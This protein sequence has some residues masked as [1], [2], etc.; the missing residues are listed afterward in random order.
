MA[1]RPKGNVDNAA[2]K[3]ADRPIKGTA[4]GS[5]RKASSKTFDGKVSGRASGMVTSTGTPAVTPSA[6]AAGSGSP[7][8]S[9]PPVSPT[10]DTAARRE[11]QRYLQLTGFPVDMTDFFL[12]KIAKGELPEDAGAEDYT[13]IAVE[14]P[15]FQA[16]FPVIVEQMKR[17]KAGDA[18][19]Q[20]MMPGAV[21]E[22]E[23]ALAEVADD[24]GLSSWVS[25]PEQIS[26]LIL[27]N[28]SASE[29]TERINLAAYA[30]QSAPEQ[31]RKAFIEHQG[32]TEGNLVGYF[33][34]PD[35]EEGEIR[36]QVTLGNIM[37]AA[38]SNG[39]G[40]NWSLAE[41]VYSRGYVPA[42]EVTGM[43]TMMSEFSRAALTSSLSSG[44]GATVT[45]DQRVDAAFGDAAG[46]AAVDSVAAQ[47]VGR[48]NTSGGAAEDRTGVS[49]LGVASTT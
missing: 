6:P 33:L 15:S 26:K 31:F 1:K 22:Y 40:N 47:R 4:S 2:K 28:V 14:H 3:S 11:L 10:G 9:N 24:Y 32:L 39:F 49:G 23:K 44:L 20:V 21:R 17:L 19:V 42:G 29:A 7:T 41:R 35:R 8:N 30:A 38:I 16:R 34:D 18:T 37:G 48:F 25:S 36:K 13:M 27:G 12:D 5:V 46:Q 43:D 45:E